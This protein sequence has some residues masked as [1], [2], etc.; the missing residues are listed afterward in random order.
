MELAFGSEDKDPWVKA[1]AQLD[2]SEVRSTIQQ[3]RVQFQRVNVINDR[4]GFGQ[5]D[6]DM[7]V[8]STVGTL[9]DLDTVTGQAG[10]N[11]TP[12]PSNKLQALPF[13]NVDVMRLPQN[14]N[15]GMGDGDAWS[16]NARLFAHSWSNA[17]FVAGLRPN[18][19]VRRGQF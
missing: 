10:G 2:V 12:L 18:R 3:L 6:G 11:A 16:P 4:E 9:G 7:Y 19:H 5:G 8:Y 13:G 1:D 14:G 17:Q 15:R